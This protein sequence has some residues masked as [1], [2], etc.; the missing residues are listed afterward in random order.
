VLLSSSSFHLSYDNPSLLSRLVLPWQDS[1]TT[2]RRRAK[3]AHQLL[4]ILDAQP[5]KYVF[6]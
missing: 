2:S 6:S 4:R 1:L 5:L 3:I